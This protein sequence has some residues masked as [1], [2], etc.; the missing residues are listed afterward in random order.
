MQHKVVFINWYGPQRVHVSS[1]VKYYKLFQIL[2]IRSI[3]NLM[4]WVPNPLYDVFHGTMYAVY[5]AVQVTR[6]I[7]W[8]GHS[9]LCIQFAWN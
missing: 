1:T 4:H 2:T 5:A 8:P 3:L 6:I 7:S 9:V